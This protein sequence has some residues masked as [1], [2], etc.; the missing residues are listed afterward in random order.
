[1]YSGSHDN[2]SRRNSSHINEHSFSSHSGDEEYSHAFEDKFLPKLQT[3]SRSRKR[4]QRQ[5]FKDYL[6]TDE[7]I[8]LDVY[9]QREAPF[10]S[11]KH[12]SKTSVKQA[13]RNKQGMHTRSSEDNSQEVYKKYQAE[14]VE[15][16]KREEVQ[17]KKSP[18]S[19]FFNIK[20]S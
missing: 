18:K 11:P 14:V 1:M 4:P 6:Y 5:V 13:A 7:I 10:I 19:E 15:T 12:A 17:V 8:S 20:C 3:R 2:G 9:P 16:H